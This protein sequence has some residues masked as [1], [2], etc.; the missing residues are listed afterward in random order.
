MS[1]KPQRK[2]LCVGLLCCSQESLLTSWLETALGL[3]VRSLTWRQ[4]LGLVSPGCDRSA[5]RSLGA[6]RGSGRD[7]AS[8]SSGCWQSPAP[9][10]EPC[11][12]SPAAGT[13]SL[14][15]LGLHQL[16]KAPCFYGFL[17]WPWACRLVQGDLLPS[18]L[19]GRVW[20]RLMGPPCQTAEVT[21]RRM[22][23][24]E[25][26]ADPDL[27]QGLQLSHALLVYDTTGFWCTG[28]PKFIVSI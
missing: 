19:G 9:S 15:G 21:A 1:P 18:S 6:C 23:C 14:V 11:L 24:P 4:A 27:L 17:W 2:L 8:R 5:S 16:V 28:L 10:H 13:G 25:A 3:W 7:G 20:T 12:L 26:S 22:P